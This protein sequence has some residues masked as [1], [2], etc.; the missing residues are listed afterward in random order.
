MSTSTNKPTPQR[1]AKTQKGLSYSW[2]YVVGIFLV[3][4]GVILPSLRLMDPFLVPLAWGDFVTLM[5]VCAVFPLAGLGILLKKSFGWYLFYGFIALCVLGFVWGTILP[6]IAGGFDRI[7][8]IF[9][10][11]SLVLATLFSLFLVLQVKYW[12][13]RTVS[14]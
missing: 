3:P 6:F 8:I 7:L 9:A 1:D 11:I 5:A 10:S 2:G 4:L 14:P 13:R 12:R